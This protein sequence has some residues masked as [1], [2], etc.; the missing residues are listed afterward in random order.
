MA[1]LQG[2]CESVCER[3]EGG[4]V[5]ASAV[6]N[7]TSLHAVAYLLRSCLLEKLAGQL[8]QA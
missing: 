8:G 6:G 4:P 3:E 7:C 5:S 1:S 2:E